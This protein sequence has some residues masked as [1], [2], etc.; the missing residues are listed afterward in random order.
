MYLIRYDYQGYG[1]EQVFWGNEAS[2]LQRVAVLLGDGATDVELY[3][4]TKLD[5]RHQPRTR[6]D[7]WID[8][9]GGTNVSYNV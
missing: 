4:C 3:Y 6:Y 1:E 7:V 5:V 8:K 9:T 2:A